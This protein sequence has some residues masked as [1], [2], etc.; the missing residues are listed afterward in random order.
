QM[1]KPRVEHVSGLSPAIAIE[2]KTVGSTPRST[3]GTVTE[4]YD[5]LRILFARLGQPYCPRCDI[6]VSTQSTD[7]VV[8]QLLAFPRDTRLLLLAPQEVA[9]GDSYDKLWDR[10]RSQGYRRVRVNGQTC[11][12]DEPPELDR[13]SRHVVE[14]VID[15]VTVGSGTRKRFAESVEQA[16]DQGRGWLRVA[17][18][19]D[20]RPEANWRVD[21]Y[22]LHRA[23][24]QCGDSFD[25][26][27]PN[28]FSFNSV[29]GWCPTCEGLGTQQGTDLSALVGDSTRTLAEGGVTAWPN[30][31]EN[32]LFGR[33]LSA[34]ARETGLPLDVPFERLDARHKRIVLSGLGERWITVPTDSRPASEGGGPG[35]QVQYKGL[36]PA[37][38]E[39]GHIN[40]SFQQRLMN[41]VGEVPCPAC[42]G[43]RLRSDA[44]AVRLSDRTLQEVTQ[45]PLDEALRFLKGLKLKAAEKRVAAD[46]L[47]EVTGRLG[48]LVEVGLDYLT[49]GRAMPTLSGGESQRIRL[50]GQVGR[51]LTGVLYVLDEP[52]I[53][54]HPRDNGRLLQAL[55][56]LRDL[57]N[58]VLLVEHDREVLA[59]A[60]RLYD[61]G[62]GA[63]RFGGTV[64]AQGPATDLERNA[65]SLTGQ[66]LGGQQQIAVPS[67]RRLPAGTQPGQGVTPGGG[68]LELLGATHHNLKRVDLRVPLGALVC[69][70]GVSGSGK[71]SLVQ[72]TLAA[73][74]GRFLHLRRESPGAY[75]DLRGLKL[76]DKLI[77]VNQQPLGSTPASNPATYT[78]VFDLIREVFTALPEAKV[79]GYREGRF[80]FNRPGGRCEACEGNGQKKIEMH[81]LPDVWVE[82]DECRGKRFNPETLAVR[83][84][85]QS[86]ADVLEMSIGQAHE[87]FENIPKIRAILATLC[88]VGLDYLT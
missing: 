54:L 3:V 37:L 38:E 26:L 18:V 80:S 31:Q 82:C 67:Q 16:L 10:L 68:W 88:A 11:T 78:G 24:T 69:V 59:A 20:S 87:L 85:G 72:G 34:I 39:L 61:F 15:R 50:A 45:M 70:T 40:Y 29:L 48:F 84:R 43:S 36:N 60:D 53:G 46:L 1:P 65:L 47:R 44:A 77:E 76:I 79:R 13:R 58:T 66:Y 83:Y 71:S 41:V 2:Q 7:Q 64:T 32:R 74:V 56:S 49:L 35:F 75:R 9:V 17:H 73:A 28:K 86:I 62:P 12:L 21:S 33:V 19:D 5:Y 30:P 55:R 25:N 22:S 57:G 27:T 81:F 42:Q 63:G 4:I 8:A 23:C 6:P 51:S 14:I 52:T